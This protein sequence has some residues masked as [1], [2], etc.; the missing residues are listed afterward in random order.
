MWAR[1]KALIS[2]SLVTNTES[3]N[4]AAVSKK[5]N[6]DFPGRRGDNAGDPA[7]VKLETLEMELDANSVALESALQELEGMAG[8]DLTPSE[9]AREAVLRGLVRFHR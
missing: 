5:M 9:A 7:E 2:N 6:D 3:V 1:A 8:R 4:R